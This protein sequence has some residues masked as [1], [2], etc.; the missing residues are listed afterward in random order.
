MTQPKTSSAPPAATEVP[1]RPPRRRIS[2][3][4]MLSPEVIEMKR[5]QEEAKRRAARLAAL[6]APSPDLSPELVPDPFPSYAVTATE[7]K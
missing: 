6:V 3:S 2:G 4:L 5:E 1:S 7:K